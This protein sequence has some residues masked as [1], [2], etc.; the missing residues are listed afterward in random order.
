MLTLEKM[1]EV[2]LDTLELIIKETLKD[3][4]DTIIFK[5]MDKNEDV[6]FGEIDKIKK[7]FLMN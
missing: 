3:Y 2:P 7:F 6:Q 1:N 4:L 5:K